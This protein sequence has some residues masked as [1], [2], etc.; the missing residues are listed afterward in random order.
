MGWLEVAELSF[1]LSDN[2]RYA[3]MTIKVIETKEMPDSIL[4]SGIL[5]VLVNGVY[6]PA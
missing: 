3:P 1:V 4:V 6:V 5:Y 2:E